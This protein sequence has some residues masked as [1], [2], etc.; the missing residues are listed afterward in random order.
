[1]RDLDYL[2]INYLF[3]LLEVGLIGKIKF[4]KEKNSIQI[5][6]KNSLYAQGI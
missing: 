4:F 5:L 3:F 1:M 2:I 6:N